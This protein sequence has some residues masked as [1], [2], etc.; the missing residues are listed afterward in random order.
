MKK[1]FIILGL[2]ITVAAAACNSPESTTGSST[3]STTLNRDSARN[4]ADTT[5][6]MTDT[7]TMR[8]DT[9]T[10]HR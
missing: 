5:G 6:R 2:A 3:D 8:H 10:Q 7:S 4:R 1:V 9:T